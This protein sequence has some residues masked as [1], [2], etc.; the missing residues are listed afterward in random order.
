MP[1]DLVTVEA[2]QAELCAIHDLGARSDRCRELY[3]E[4]LPADHRALLLHFWA[5]GLGRSGSQFEALRL[6]DKGLAVADGERRAH[7]LVLKANNL[8]EV[9]FVDE[10]PAC[11]DALE[12]WPFV[13]NHVAAYG[14]ALRAIAEG[15]LGRDDWW[16]PF[17]VAEAALIPI[18]GQEKNV[19]WI[20]DSAATLALSRRQ[21]E[22]ATE[23]AR[24]VGHPD[25]L[26]GARVLLAEAQAQQG[27]W[28]LAVEVLASPD[29]Y[30]HP[31]LT[32][33]R[34]QFL[35]ALLCVHQGDLVGARRHL[36][37]ALRPP[38]PGQMASPSIAL[39]NRTTALRMRLCRGGGNE[40]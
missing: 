32:Q 23:W 8:Y 15:L 39:N 20:Q 16:V 38:S 31:P 35:H 11:L 21:P 33:A 14:L 2:L 26:I 27:D 3:S 28:S 34:W 22:R 10:I 1:S 19:G 7:L 37:E 29:L 25:W 17:E 6:I 36:S 9:G 5:A 30:C 40:T 13:P 12:A 4:D 24:R 18:P